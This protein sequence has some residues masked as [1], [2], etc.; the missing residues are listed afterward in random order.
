MR[1]ITRL[2]VQAKGPG[3]IDDLGGPVGGIDHDVAGMNGPMNHVLAVDLSESKGNLLGDIERLGH[4]EWA[5][6]D[7]RRQRGIPE[8][9]LH[10]SD[11]IS[12][13]LQAQVAHDMLRTDGLGDRVLTR[14][15]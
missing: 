13:V 8:S 11:A 4:V 15:T 5:L 12:F 9:F 10:E 3:K 1:R 14:K 6:C 2:L 7:N